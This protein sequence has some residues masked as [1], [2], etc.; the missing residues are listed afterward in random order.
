MVLEDIRE[1]I[2]LIFEIYLKGNYL[3]A[4]NFFQ[5]SLKLDGDRVGVELGRMP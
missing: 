1:G 2:V 4:Y 5:N 3:V